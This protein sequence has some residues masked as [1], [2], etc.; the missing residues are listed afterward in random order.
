MRTYPSDRF[1]TYAMLEDLKIFGTEPFRFPM[2]VKVLERVG[3]TAPAV[4]IFEPSYSPPLS[5]Q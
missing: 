3:T 1:N 5:L 2:S 4:K